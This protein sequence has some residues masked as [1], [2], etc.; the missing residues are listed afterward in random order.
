MA[1][2]IILESDRLR[3]TVNPLVGGTITAIEHLEL[4]KSVLGTVPWTTESTPLDP[5]TV[6]DEP[7]WLTRFTGGWPILF[8]NGGDACTFRGVFH[9]FH[10]EGSIAPWDMQTD[11]SRLFLRRRFTTVPVEMEREIAL[12]GDLLTIR[13]TARVLGSESAT[14]MW[15][16][17]PS[18]GSDLLE[19]PVEIQSSARGVMSDDHYDA[20]ADPLRPGGKGRWP[21]VAGKAGPFDL[22]RPREPV[23]AVACLHDFAGAWV[24]I[25]RLD[26]SV[27]VALSWDE[28]VFPFAWL[29]F[30]LG[31]R[32]A[33]PWNSRTRLIGVEPNTTWPA[34]GLAAAEERG[35]RLL[36][37]VPGKDVTAWIRLQVFK[38]AG[39]VRGVEG[40][41]RVIGL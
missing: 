26:N 14:V 35:G 31:G 19:G 33:P 16:H 34:H 11:Q 25:R 30:E 1:A 2:V 39:A 7:I 29:W 32:T 18:F 23:T 27:G 6:R 37:L 15:G 22:S 4:G 17:H 8:P 13:E 3:I 36:T 5:A 9:G 24:T 10:G 40:D 41:G 20:A 21:M 28:R 38:P 12:D